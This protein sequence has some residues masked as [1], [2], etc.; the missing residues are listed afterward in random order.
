MVYSP[1]SGIAAGD[2]QHVPVLVVQLH[3]ITAVVVTRPA[4]FLAEQGVMQDRFGG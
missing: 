3:G 4:G 2:G 1:V